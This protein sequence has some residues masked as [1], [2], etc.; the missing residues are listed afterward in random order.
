MSCVFAL[1]S[2]T[3]AAPPSTA[4]SYQ[5]SLAENGS[6][7]NG[8]TEMTFKLWDAVTGGS[9]IGGTLVKTVNVAEGVFSESL[10]FGSGA[11]AINQAMWLEIIVEGQSLG[12]TPL[13]AVPFSLNT[14]GFNVLSNGFV[15]LNNAN[16]DSPF[17]VDFGSVPA[18]GRAMRL[19]STALD[20]TFLDFSNPNGNWSLGTNAVGNGTNGNQFLLFDNIHTRYAVTVQ[21]GTG[22]VGIARTDPSERL[23][24]N[25]R[26]KAQ[27][28]NA[29]NARFADGGNDFQIGSDSLG[30]Y[31]FDVNRQNYAMR[32]MENTGRVGIGTSSPAT[33]LDVNG[34]VTI[35]GGADLVEG[36]ESSCGTAFEPGTV[37]SIDPRNPGQLMCAEEPYDRKVAGVVS[38]ANGIRP[39]IKLGQDGA[40][41]GDIAVAMTGRVYVKASAEN[42]AIMPGD[43]L[44]TAA[45]RGHAMKA[46]D[47]DLSDGAVIG[48]AMTGLEEGTGL[49][50]VLVNL[51]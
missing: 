46:T 28:L 36:F 19:H 43:R 32:I 23:D 11:Y 25:G 14:R 42:G 3:Q 34:A 4:F 39:G 50:L 18:N 48:K 37:L 51:Q 45:L 12:R 7:A 15:G 30:M 17:V 13:N 44:T 6:P 29:V 27:G 22:N 2:Q 16:P 38:G 49:V 8:P 20:K 41:D 24:V 5:G 35:R 40:M 33:M 9:Q 21:A 10:D 47:G 31:F 26:V 1:S